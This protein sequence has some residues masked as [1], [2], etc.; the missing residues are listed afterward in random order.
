MPHTPYNPMTG[1]YLPLGDDRIVGVFVVFSN[2]NGTISEEG[3]RILC[4]DTRGNNLV[5]VAK[6]YMLRRSGFHG[7]TVNGVSYEF[8]NVN[9]RTASVP[10]EEDDESQI[11]TPDYI[12][13]EII[14]AVK[15]RV[16][17]VLDDDT[18]GFC[19]W[20]DINAAGRC[21]AAVEVEEEA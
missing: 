10:D 6:P 8:T 14:F 19:D 4:T 20:E 17:L 3:S 2:E 15:Y 5:Y 18:E 1:K 7:E 16:Q 11:I 9:Q 21:W 13:G 12:A